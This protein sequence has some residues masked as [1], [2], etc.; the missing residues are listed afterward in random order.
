L[1]ARTL[2]EKAKAALSPP[3][4]DVEVVLSLDEF[5]K[6]TKHEENKLRETAKDKRKY[7]KKN[8][9]KVVSQKWA[10]M[11]EGKNGGIQ[12]GGKIPTPVQKL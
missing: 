9:E 12:V 8:P 4:F 5:K 1:I 3:N 11:E 6:L 2:L 10:K 7:L